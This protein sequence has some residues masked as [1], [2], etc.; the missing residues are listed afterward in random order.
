MRR[1]LRVKP[2]S[3]AARARVVASPGRWRHGNRCRWDCCCLS[4]FKTWCIELS[5]TPWAVGE[6]ALAHVVGNSVEAAYVRSDLFDQRRQ[7]MQEWAEFLER[8]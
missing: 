6:A 8:P 2:V 7:L 3:A 5:A 1:M 4:A